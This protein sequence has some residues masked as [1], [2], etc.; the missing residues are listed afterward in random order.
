MFM[1]ARKSRSEHIVAY[2][3]AS[4]GLLVSLLALYV[5]VY[6]WGGWEWASI[7]VILGHFFL[8]IAGPLSI[9][10]A[11]FK[12]R[13]AIVITIAQLSLVAISSI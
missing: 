8:I 5:K 9:W 3:L 11:A 4:A 7:H 2:A 1:E 12:P 6:F 10:M 13:I